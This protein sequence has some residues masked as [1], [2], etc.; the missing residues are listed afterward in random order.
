MPLLA[1][2]E[3]RRLK[4]M[5]LTHNS[6]GLV[7]VGTTWGTQP[8]P[9][10]RA[11][12]S[13]LNRPSVLAFRSPADDVTGARCAQQA[14]PQACPHLPAG[15]HTERIARSGRLRPR[16][17]AGGGHSCSVQKHQRGRGRPLGDELVVRNGH[18]D[19]ERTRDGHARVRARVQQRQT[20]L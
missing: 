9:A 4:D 1:H 10:G 7:L 2:L 6:S 12:A 19:S 14:P 16:L 8:R 17:C 5:P 18:L 3:L 15:A 20:L 11:S 13:Y